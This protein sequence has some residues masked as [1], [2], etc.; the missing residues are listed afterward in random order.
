MAAI[1]SIAAAAQI[2]P[3]YLPHGLLLLLWKVSPKFQLVL[4]A[5]KDIGNESVPIQLAQCRF[6]GPTISNEIIHFFQIKNTEVIISNST[7]KLLKLPKCWLQFKKKNF[8]VSFIIIFGTLLLPT[9]KENSIIT[10]FCPF[11]GCISPRSV[12]MRPFPTRYT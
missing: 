8:T 7:W 4:P 3:S 1:D 5:V 12:Q 6:P 11:L 2:D 10:I 9:A